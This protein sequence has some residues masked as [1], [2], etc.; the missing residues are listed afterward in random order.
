MLSGTI[1]ILVLT[2][3]SGVS[4]RRESV[5]SCLSRVAT[6]ASL[7]RKVRHERGNSKAVFSGQV[8]DIVERK[9][10]GSSENV[11][12]FRVIESW[13]RVR[14]KTVKVV[15]PHPTPASCGYDFQ[16]GESYLVYVQIADDN[17]L[18]TGICSRT[19]ELAKATEDL[20]ILGRGKRL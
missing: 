5:C 4:M 18:W 2:T 8:L 1:A 12:T 3:F 15:T 10:G 19:M 20:Q 13:K 9:T 16:V 11:V 14:T 6:D 17:E 7:S